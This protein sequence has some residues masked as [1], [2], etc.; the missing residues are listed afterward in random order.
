MA[1]VMPLIVVL[2]SVA[3]MEVVSASNSV[4][5]VVPAPLEKLTEAG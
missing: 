3:V 5:L 2:C 1:E 4:T